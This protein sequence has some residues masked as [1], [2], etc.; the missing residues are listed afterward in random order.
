M[1]T[2]SCILSFERFSLARAIDT[3]EKFSSLVWGFRIYD[4]LFTDGANA[5]Y[6]LQKHGKIFADIGL[7]E[8]DPSFHHICQSLWAAGADIISIQSTTDLTRS[9]SHSLTLIPRNQLPFYNEPPAKIPTELFILNASSVA[10]LTTIEF[11]NLLASTAAS[12]NI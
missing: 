1:K 7:L 12:A 8:T 2:K 5:I 6:Q 9:S 10:N 4:L 11:S 3:A